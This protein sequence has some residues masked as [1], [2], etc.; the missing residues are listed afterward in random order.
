MLIIQIALGI[1]L[2]F[3]IIA[4]LDTILSYGLV[5]LVVLVGVGAIIWALSILPNVVSSLLELPSQL[6]FIALA[7]GVLI[8]GIIALALV[9]AISAEIA[10]KILG[11]DSLT[12]TSF[13][14]LLQAKQISKEVFFQVTL[15]YFSERMA[16][17][18]L[19][20]LILVFVL[21]YLTDYFNV[22]SIPVLV[23]TAFY[24]L[25]F[26]LRKLYKK[27]KSTQLPLS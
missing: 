4:N 9:G 15:R 11:I 14:D 6:P 10:S 27:L 26:G 1:V 23:V 25:T 21:G 19:H 12:T 8:G 3:L 18:M 2:A 24:A 22:V 5:A 17:G 13:M 16:F 7:I 20:F